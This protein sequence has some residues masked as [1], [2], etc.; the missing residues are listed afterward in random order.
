MYSTV[1][2][3]FAWAATG[4]G[5]SLLPAD[6]AAQRLETDIPL[7]EGGYGLGITQLAPG[8]IGHTGQTAG[9][10]SVGLYNPTSGATCAGIT[11]SITGAVG[12]A[13]TC[14][15]IFGLG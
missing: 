15:L 4:M 7:P 12:L 5:T 8:W 2:D 3:L 13:H 14:A 1:A 11:N 6:L 10:S 9:W